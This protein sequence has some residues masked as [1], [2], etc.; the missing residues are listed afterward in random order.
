MEMNMIYNED[1]LITM[2]GMPDNFVDLTV[3]SPPYD[4]LREYDGYNFDFKNVAEELFRVTKKGGVVV[5]VVGDATVDGSET[6]TS[7]RQALF[8]K[9]IGFRLFDTMIYIKNGGL[10]SGSNK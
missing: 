2:A 3:T 6:G 8:F 1:C 4:D 10:N 9:D 7:F 5:W